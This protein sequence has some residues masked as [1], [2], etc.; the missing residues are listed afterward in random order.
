[1]NEALRGNR[2]QRKLVDRIAAGA[3]IA[4]G[5]GVVVPLVVI[6]GFLFIEGLPAL[7][8]D[9][10]RDNPGPVGTP[11]GG[12]KNSI[13]GSAILLALALAFGLPLAIATGVYLAEYGRTRL[14]FAIRFLVDVLAGVPSITIGLFVY[15]AV[16]LNMDKARSR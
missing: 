4:A 5:V 14:G 7:H 1:M 11:G 9:L 8:I 16:V 12:I 15:T 6:L 3:I 10:I 13:I 2:R